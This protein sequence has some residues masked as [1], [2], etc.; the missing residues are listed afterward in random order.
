M[1]RISHLSLLEN[2]KPHLDL[3]TSQDQTLDSAGLAFSPSSDEFERLERIFFR[4]IRKVRTYIFIH[5]LKAKLKKYPV[6]KQCL[7]VFFYGGGGR[8]GGQVVIT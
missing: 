5:L 7:V 2:F 3:S 4:R 6:C 1:V 8:G